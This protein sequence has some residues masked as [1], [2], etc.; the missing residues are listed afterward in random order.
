MVLTY[1][2]LCLS[3]VAAGAIN[4][5]AGGGTLLTFF[6]L[7]T[8]LSPLGAGQAEVFG[9]A[10]STVALVPGSLAGAW[11]YRRQMQQTRRWLLL[12]LGPSLVGGA[13][14]SLLVTRL[15]PSYFAALVPWLLLLAS[16]LFLIDP[17]L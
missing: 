2:G 7:T 8:V 11:G 6:A 4:A 10:T 17:L 1:L 9:N 13:I 14:G 3:A 15:D 5:V 12:L 16:M